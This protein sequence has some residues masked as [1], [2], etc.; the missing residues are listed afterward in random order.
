MKRKFFIIIMLALACIAKAQDM[1]SPDG[2]FTLHFS[3]NAQGRPTYQL[4]FEGKEVVKTSGLGLELKKEEAGKQ[5]TFDN[6]QHTQASTIDRKADEEGIVS[7]ADARGWE[8]RLF[9]ADELA[10][11]PGEFP[12]SEFV[13]ETVGVGN[14]CERAACACGGALLLGKRSE[15]GVTVALG[16]R[17][18]KLSF[19]GPAEGGS[20]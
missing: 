5:E 6:T 11:V 9:G 15:D 19:D 12:S 14:V 18:P 4:S 2:R 13:R 16:Y 3:L 8:L 10:A 20:R 7:L 17:E 1:K